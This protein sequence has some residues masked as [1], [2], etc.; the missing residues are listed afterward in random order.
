MFGGKAKRRL[1]NF[2]GKDISRLVQPFSPCQAS[3]RKIFV[4]LDIQVATC[5]RGGGGPAGFA[6]CVPSVCRGAVGSGIASR[7]GDPDLD[8]SWSET[9]SRTPALPLWTFFH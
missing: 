9:K 2:S 5:S 4:F 3:P 6:R 1:E 8:S 7:S